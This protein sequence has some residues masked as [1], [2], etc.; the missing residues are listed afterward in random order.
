MKRLHSILKIVLISLIFVLIFTSCK[1]P[2]VCQHRDENDDSLCDTVYYYSE[3][4]P[5]TE[6]NFW[7]YID[8]EPTVW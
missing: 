8:G 7:H 3:T 4:F 5:T 1:K 6:G 2:S